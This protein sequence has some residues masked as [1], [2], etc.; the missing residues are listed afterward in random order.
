MIPA[1]IFFMIGLLVLE[2]LLHMPGGDPACLNIDL[3]SVPALEAEGPAEG[4]CARLLLWLHALQLAG[5]AYLFAATAQ[6]H[7]EWMLSTPDGQISALLLLLQVVRMF[8][9]K[10]LNQW[11][12]ASTAALFQLLLLILQVVF[13]PDPGQF[14]VQASPEAILVPAASLAVLFLL[15]VTQPFIAT[16]YLR[17]FSREGTVFYYHLPPLIFSEQWIRRLTRLS[18][19]AALALSLLLAAFAVLGGYSPAQAMLHAAPALLLLSAVRLFENRMKLHHPVAVTLAMS[20]WLLRLGWL[21]AGPLMAGDG[22][23]V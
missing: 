18:A 13:G 12:V 1:V 8:N 11:A 14:R 6:V 19:W 7:N 20:A 17:L 9:T 10:V 3:E 21:L 4:A 23:T 15:G 5:L 22:W 2:M 16:Y